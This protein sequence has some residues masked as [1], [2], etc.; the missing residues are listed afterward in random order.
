MTRLS[1]ARVRG[2]MMLLLYSAISLSLLVIF[3][4]TLTVNFNIAMVTSHLVTK[5]PNH[6]ICSES[7]VWCNA[8]PSSTAYRFLKYHTKQD[9]TEHPN[10]P[11]G[12]RKST[13]AQIVLSMKASSSNFSYQTTVPLADK[14]V[15]DPSLAQVKAQ[16]PLGL[17]SGSLKGYLVVVNFEEQLC[18]AVYDLYQVANIAKSW[19]MTLVEPHV[20][21]S[22]FKFQYPPPTITTT[23]QKLQYRDI[24]DLV[25][26]N[27]LFKR[28][29]K[30]THDVITPFDV[31][32][33]DAA[34]IHH[35]IIL[36]Y[37]KNYEEPKIC[38]TIHHLNALE[39]KNRVS[40][41]MRLLSVPTWNINLTSVNLVDVPHS[42]MCVDTRSAI[43]FHHLLSKD[44]KIKLIMQS[45]SNI[46][47]LIPNWRGIRTEPHRYFYYDP[48]YRQPPCGVV[49]ALPHSTRIQ[50]ATEKYRNLHQLDHPFVGVHIRL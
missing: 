34:H 6:T 39:L 12:Q 43:D 16:R 41:Y 20:Q 11:H 10:K 46:L 38:Q 36:Y 47:V 37:L 21:G 32:A 13:Q 17:S 23:H 18:S 28:C 42:V 50:S 35:V 31:F 5:S 9:K 3:V 4:C 1:P 22:Q 25:E 33:R 30:S 49:H 29:L 8:K 15:T 24:F 7:A 27:R 48:S 40:A 26:T 14:N 19:N 2:K 45:H 44:K